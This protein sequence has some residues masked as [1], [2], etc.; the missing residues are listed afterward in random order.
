MVSTCPVRY[1]LTLLLFVHDIRSGRTDFAPRR[2]CCKLLENLPN[3]LG[4]WPRRELTFCGC[5]ALEFEGLP[6]QKSVAK[7]ALSSAEIG[8]CVTQLLCSPNFY[9]KPIL[10]G[11]VDSYWRPWPEPPSWAAEGVAGAL[12]LRPFSTEATWRFNM[13]MFKS[14]VLGSAAGLLAVGGAQAADLPVKAKA[15]EYVRVCSL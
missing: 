5:E 8:S 12:R 13:R 11:G 14:L 9:I 6:R 15:V 7:K 4:S 3:N 1:F 2:H 10:R